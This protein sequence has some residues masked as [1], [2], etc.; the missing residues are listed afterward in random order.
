MWL[1]DALLTFI[2][3]FVDAFI[4]NTVELHMYIT[5]VY[6]RLLYRNSCKG[7][8]IVYKQIK[9]VNAQDL[10]L[11]DG[12]LIIFNQDAYTFIY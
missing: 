1:L 8:Y 11:F 10:S 6:Y 3:A 2:T 5:D 7:L 9:Y 12:I 4:A